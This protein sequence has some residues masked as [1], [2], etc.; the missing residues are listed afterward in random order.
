[1]PSW[2]DD[3]TAADLDI[4]EADGREAVLATIDQRNAKTGEIKRT[5]V[6]IWA[7][8]HLDRAKA[9]VDALEWIKDIYDLATR[10]TWVEACGLF[11]EV[12][13]DQLDTICLL[14]RCTRDH[15]APQHQHLGPQALD[16]TYG[17]GA[18]MTLWEKLGHLVEQQDPR[19]DELSEVQF[20][21]L[22]GSIDKA[23]N[24]G[25]LVVISGR[26]R[27][28]FVLGLVQRLAISHKPNSSLPS[29]AT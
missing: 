20:W 21:A 18:L 27:D 13:V 22:V 11:G 6:R 2:M 15:D 3:K 14:A 8:S 29:T 10:P 26:A 7:P 23:R 25:P 4:I 5:S 17:T 12:Y 24:V 1:M 19:V 9:R 28:N 16:H